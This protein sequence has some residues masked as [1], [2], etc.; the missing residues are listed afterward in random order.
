MGNTEQSDAILEAQR[1]ARAHVEDGVSEREN[2]LD[3]NLGGRLR[4]VPPGIVD[5]TE[6]LRRDER[7]AGCLPLVMEGDTV[8][9][10]LKTGQ[11]LRYSLSR[12][13]KSALSGR[14]NCLTDAPS[15]MDS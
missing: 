1:S 14:R 11:P 5:T 6:D 9:N 3:C 2:G 10:H 15:S 8:G 4:S 13:H 12:M 7:Q